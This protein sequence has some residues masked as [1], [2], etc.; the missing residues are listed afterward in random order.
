MQGQKV[1]TLESG[2]M[3]PGY[4]AIIWNGTN[5]K[6]SRVSTGMYIYSIQTNKFQ[7]VRKMLFL[8]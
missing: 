3:T 4:H 8:K 5:D 2:R 6:G 1:R 7:A